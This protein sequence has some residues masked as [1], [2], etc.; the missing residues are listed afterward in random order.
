MCLVMNRYT[1]TEVAEKLG[2]DREVARGLVR[3]LTDANVGLAEMKGD[4]APAPGKSGRAEKVYEF[5][6]GFE[7][8]LA[9]LLTQAELT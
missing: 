1:I 6:E 5:V 8:S 3:F 4:R 7:R 9:E 2:V